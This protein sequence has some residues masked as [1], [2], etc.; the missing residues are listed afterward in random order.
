[1]ECKVNCNN[2]PLLNIAAASSHVA[3]IRDAMDVYTRETCVRFVRRTN[4]RDYVMFYR[5]DG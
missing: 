3:A 2:H 4:Q 5:G 1:M